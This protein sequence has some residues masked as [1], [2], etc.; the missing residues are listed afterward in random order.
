M[1]MDSKTA[2]GF[3]GAR[4]VQEAHRPIAEIDAD[5]AAVSAR[6][7]VLAQE[8]AAAVRARDTQ[9]LQWFDDDGLTFNAISI[10]TGLSFHTVKMFLWNHGRTVEGR[11]ALRAQMAS[12]QPM[13]H[14]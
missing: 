2:D 5:I 11:N 10:R 12:L 7:R 9:I 6:R 1:S 3:D 13:G 8:K 4:A 14:A